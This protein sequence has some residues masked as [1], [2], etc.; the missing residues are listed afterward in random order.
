M[1]QCIEGRVILSAEMRWRIIQHVRQSLPGEAVGL[2][3]GRLNGQVD[4]VLPLP[5]IAEGDHAFLADPLAQFSALRRIRAAQLE[6]LAIYHSH[7]GGDTN[8][9]VQDLKYARAWRCAHLIVAV[10]TQGATERLEAFQFLQS[11]RIEKVSLV[12]DLG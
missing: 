11:G 9:S 8:P 5:N 2:L 1:T 10:T 12:V 4:L 3:A 6:L 7:P